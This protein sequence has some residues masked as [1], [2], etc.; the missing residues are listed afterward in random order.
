M[1]CCAV[2]CCAVLCCAGLG[3]VMVLVMP[4]HLILF[5]SCTMLRCADL[6]QALLSSARLVGII[7]LL[8]GMTWCM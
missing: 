2:L 6:C 1:L 8:A 7:I 5:L 3:L 4:L